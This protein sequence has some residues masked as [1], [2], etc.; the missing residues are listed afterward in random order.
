MLAAMANDVGD[1]LAELTG[2]VGQLGELHARRD[3]LVVTAREAGAT[4]AQLA[5][6]LGVSVQAAHKRYRDVRL[7]LQGRPWKEPRLPL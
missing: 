7:D 4:W 3:A 1:I 5:D 6:V 2:I